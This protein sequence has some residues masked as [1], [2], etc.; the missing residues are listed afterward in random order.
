MRAFWAPFMAKMRVVMFCFSIFLFPP[1]VPPPLRAPWQHSQA[2]PDL[3]VRL[4]RVVD[5]HKLE[6]ASS[7]LQLLLLLLLRGYLRPVLQPYE[8]IPRQ[9]R[10]GGMVI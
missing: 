2:F 8:F 3:R 9:K 1:L 4:Q 10:N 6:L 7:P 5:E